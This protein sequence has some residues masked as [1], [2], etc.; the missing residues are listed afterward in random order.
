MFFSRLRLYFFRRLLKVLLRAGTETEFVPGEEQRRNGSRPRFTR[1]FQ[2]MI[3][4]LYRH[5]TTKTQ[6]S[7]KIF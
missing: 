3:I 5:C 6:T 7:Q 1:T 4:F 2:V